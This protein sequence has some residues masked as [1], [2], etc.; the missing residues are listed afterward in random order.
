MKARIL[1]TAVLATALS[2]CVTSDTG[3]RVTKESPKDAAAYNYQL[4][5][6]YLREGKLK[7]ARERLESS[8]RQ[9]PNV[10]GAHFT[11]AILYERIGESQMAERAYRNALRIAPDDGAVQN[12]YAVHMCSKKRYEEAERYFL[13]AA[14]NP[15]YATPEAALTNAG[16]CMRQ[17]PNLVEAERYF[18]EALNFD[19]TYGDALAQ[20]AYIS[21]EE[22]N[23]LSAR[24][25]IARFMEKH[26]P[27]SDVLLLAYRVELA[28]GD[29]DAAQEYART[30]L[31]DFPTSSE[32]ATLQRGGIG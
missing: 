6:A 11:L 21:F 17:V 30:I 1:I 9:N 16:V 24:A 7:L 8:I 15:L 20:L 4:G 23:Y 18:R 27:S 32:A 2:A 22:K 29:D 19:P 25:F 3:G 28:L 14:N 10:A 26:T 13:K 31:Q 5:A 12:S